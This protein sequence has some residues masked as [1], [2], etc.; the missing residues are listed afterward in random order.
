[1]EGALA[2]VGNAGEWTVG[3]VDAGSVARMAFDWENLDWTGDLS[4]EHWVWRVGLTQG[5][6]G[7]EVFVDYETGEVLGELRYIIN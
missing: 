3:G 4:A 2:H 7:A 6:E 5:D 1:M